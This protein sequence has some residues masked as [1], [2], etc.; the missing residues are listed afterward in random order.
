MIVDGLVVTFAVFGIVTGIIKILD[1]F[2]K[3]SKNRD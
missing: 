1:L 3:Y 2:R